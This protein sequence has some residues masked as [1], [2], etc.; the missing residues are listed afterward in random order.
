M[1]S[2]AFTVILASLS[3]SHLATCHRQDVLSHPSPLCSL[4]TPHSPRPTLSSTVTPLIIQV[5]KKKLI[6]SWAFVFFLKLSQQQCRTCNRDRGKKY[7]TQLQFPKETTFISPWTTS[8]CK[9]IFTWQ[10][11]YFMPFFVIACPIIT[12]Q[13]GNKTKLW[14]RIEQIRS[15]L[16]E[17]QKVNIST[18]SFWF[19]W[20]KH[21]STAAGSPFLVFSLSLTS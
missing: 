6:M 14:F 15:V 20:L 21:I 7:H 19:N 11:F 3:G 5:P 17:Q 4:L 1:A 2:G 10:I 12:F 8:I 13:N 9:Q 16:S 18:Q